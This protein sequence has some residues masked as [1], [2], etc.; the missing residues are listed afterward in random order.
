MTYLWISRAARG[1]GYEIARAIVECGTEG[2]VLLDRQAELVDKAA[3]E[4]RQTTGVPVRSYHIDTTEGTSIDC[5]F[6]QVLGAFGYIDV[7]INSTG[8]AEFVRLRQ[9]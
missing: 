3:E 1:L 2:V 7:V 5:R 6:Q 9:L 8:I 4:I